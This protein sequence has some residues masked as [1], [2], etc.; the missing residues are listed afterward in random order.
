[1]QRSQ[2]EAG[3]NRLASIKRLHE[4]F[5]GVPSIR[6][7][8]R[9]GRFFAAFEAAAEL[10]LDLDFDIFRLFAERLTQTERHHEQQTPIENEWEAFSGSVLR[11]REEMRLLSERP[12]FLELDQWRARQRHRV[13]SELGLGA[14]ILTHPLIAFELSEGCSVGCRFCGI[15]AERFVGHHPYDAVEWRGFLRGLKNLFGDALGSGFLYWGTDPIDN[16]EYENFA[17]D[18]YEITSCLPQL[19]TA[20]PLKN[21]QRTRGL[22]EYASGRSLAPYRFSVLSLNKLRNIFREYSPREL[23]NVELVMQHD[24]AQQKKANAGRNFECSVASENEEDVKSLESLPTTIACVTG[25]LVNLP[26][27][28]VQMVSPTVASSR[29]PNGYITFADRRST[30]LDGC[31]DLI[32]DMVEEQSASVRRQL[33]G[34]A[35]RPDLS[36]RRV[37]EGFELENRYTLHRFASYGAL[38]DEVVRGRFNFRVGMEEDKKENFEHALFITGM[39]NAGLLEVESP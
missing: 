9:E 10:K 39:F 30:S 23:L 2:P 14:S 21:V 8:I 37:G 15:S 34:V 5:V 24:E 4:A 31:I 16:P 29:R 20:I 18:F 13:S 3:L 22:L 12:T 26:Q 1:M 28:R 36:Y 17:R 6:N 11:T 32:V 35:I 19:T 25:F 38:L 27:R 33:R 7:A